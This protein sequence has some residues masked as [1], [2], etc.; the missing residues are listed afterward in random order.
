VLI[1]KHIIGKEITV[2]VLEKDDKTFALPVIEIIT[3]EDKWYDFEHRYTPG[4]SE[5]VIPA[6]LD[7]AVYKDVQRMAVQAHTH[8]ACRDFSRSD[9]II[10]EDNDIY[11]IELNTLP[12]MTPTSLY[13][14]AA[15]AHGLSFP[16]LMDH[17]ISRAY[18]RGA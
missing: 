12:G 16:E 18:Q 5:H 6:K 1:E 9:F 15:K 8:L 14:D 4:F 13:P 2:A 3:P 17:F 11:F 7:E 10:T